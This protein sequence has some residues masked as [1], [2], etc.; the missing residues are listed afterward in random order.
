MRIENLQELNGCRDWRDSSSQTIRFEYSERTNM[1]VRRNQIRERKTLRKRKQQGASS[2]IQQSNKRW[3]NYAVPTAG[4]NEGIVPVSRLFF[5]FLFLKSVS[6]KLQMK[7]R[8]T[9]NTAKTNIVSSFVPTSC[10]IVPVN[11]FEPRLLEWF[12]KEERQQ[13]KKTKKRRNARKQ[14]NIRKFEQTNE[15][16]KFHGQP[17]QT[18]IPRNNNSTANN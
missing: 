11:E 12:G 13:K 2:E 15:M 10:G 1:C 7:H 16:L 5:K 9:Q 6:S 3:T 8:E 4:G 18:N 14:G 17:K